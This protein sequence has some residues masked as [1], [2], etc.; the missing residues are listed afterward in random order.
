MRWKGVIFHNANAAAAAAGAANASGS[1]PNNVA[2]AAAKPLLALEAPP[3]QVA[4]AAAG[5]AKQQA[6]ALGMGSN[7]ANNVAANAAANAANAARPNATPAQAANA[8]AAGAAAAGL[9]P[10]SQAAAAENAAAAAEPNLPGGSGGVNISSLKGAINQNVSVM[11]AAA[12]RAEKRR[13]NVLVSRVGTINNANL[14][15]KVNNYRRRLNSK[16]AGAAQTRAAGLMAQAQRPA[17]QR[18]A[19][20]PVNFPETKNVQVPGTNKMVHVERNNKNTKWRFS[21]SNNATKYTLLNRNAETPRIRNINNVG[22]GNLFKKG[23]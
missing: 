13:L 11:N 8:A 9:P 23:N 5:A 22:S 16:I 10:N 19:T 7:K 1:S 17:A 4:A 21:S 2:A 6:L 20:I 12:A 14:R 15:T 18:P 3:A